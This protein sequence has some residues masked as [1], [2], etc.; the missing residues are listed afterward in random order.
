VTFPYTQDQFSNIFGEASNWM[1]KERW[2]K[3]DV[4]SAGSIEARDDGFM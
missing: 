4:S 1:R 2:L 3:N